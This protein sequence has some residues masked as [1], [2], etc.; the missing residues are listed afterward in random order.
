VNRSSARKL[1]G[2]KP[3][4]RLKVDGGCDPFPPAKSQFPDPSPREGAPNRPRQRLTWLGDHRA[5]FVWTVTNVKGKLEEKVSRN[6]PA[7][8]P[9]AR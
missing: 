4:E 7:M 2:N 9:Q 1:L 3:A 5:E 8:S 6:L